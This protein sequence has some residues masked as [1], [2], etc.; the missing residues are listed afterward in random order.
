MVAAMIPP[1]TIVL[2]TDLT[3]RSDRAMERAGLLMKEWSCRLVVVHV[4]EP[5]AST[6]LSDGE[7]AARARNEL[8]EQLRDAGDRVSIRIERGV[9]ADQIRQVAQA[10]GASLLVTGVARSEWFGAVDVG[11]TVEGVLRGLDVPL[12]A[13]S[14]RPRA[15]YSRI[16]VAVDFAEVSRKALLT[17]SQLF[18][19]RALT[20]F[21][22]YH[23]PASYAAEN[24]QRY[25]DT[26]HSPAQTD[27][28]ELVAKA[29]LSDAARS[30]L[31][32]EV[33]FGNPAQKLADWTESSQVELAVVGT[34][35]RGR[36]GEFL[37]GSVAKRVLAAVS[38]D[39]LLVPASGD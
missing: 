22:A 38:C 21:H 4:I 1:T 7:L 31:Q 10:E 35:A 20:V 39:V 14:A 9:A 15:P 37:L 36:L 5:S 6:S 30:R 16:T 29:A 27:T 24:L 3:A 2:A 34:H 33:Q 8:C 13:V 28:R 26:F 17:A 12:L 11:D 18:P 25:R 32:I 23:A 19:D